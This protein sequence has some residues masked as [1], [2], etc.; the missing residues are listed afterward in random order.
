MRKILRQTIDFNV[1]LTFLLFYFILKIIGKTFLSF[2]TRFFVGLLIGLSHLTLIALIL[3]S[4]IHFLKRLLT[5][6]QKEL[7]I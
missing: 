7:E 1:E 5:V 6:K 2:Y 3:K 4:D